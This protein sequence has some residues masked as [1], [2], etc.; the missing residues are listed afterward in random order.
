M[1]PAQNLG[2]VAGPAV[3]AAAAAAAIVDHY[4][5]LTM[6]TSRTAMAISVRPWVAGPLKREPSAIA[7]V[8]WCA[9][10]V[11]IPS[12][13]GPTRT[14]RWGQAASKAL[15]VPLTGCTTSTPATM[16]PPPTGTSFVAASTAPLL[17]AVPA[18]VVGAHPSNRFPRHSPPD[19]GRYTRHTL[20]IGGSYSDGVAGSATPTSA[21]TSGGSLSTS[22]VTVTVKDITG[23]AGSASFGWTVASGGASC[24]TTNVALNAPAATSSTQSGNYSAANAVDGNTTT[25]W[26]STFADPQWLQVDLGSATSICKVV[27]NWQNS[28][29]KAFEIRTSNDGSTW[30]AIYS[31]TT[32]TGGIQTINVS[33]M[34]RYIQMY[35]TARATRYGYSLWELQV[36]A[37]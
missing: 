37:R 21:T 19:R 22:N 20:A 14:P 30:I 1:D 26:S 35:G 16:M 6:F 28:Y 12:F 27:L 24:A 36:F 31:I 15:N 17:A 23:A 9:G 18:A 7:K 3:G 5:F 29:A 2:V 25:R 13:A 8:G 4:Y 34:G 32:G 11:L 33:G 10:H